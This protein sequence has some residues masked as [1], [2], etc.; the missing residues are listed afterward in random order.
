MRSPVSMPETLEGSSMSLATLW[1][2][3]YA[4]GLVRAD[5]VVGIE[6]HPTPALTG[7]PPHW[8]LTVVLP[9]VTGS[10]DLADGAPG[11]QIAPVHRTVIQTPDHP[12]DAPAA[13]ARLLAQL[14]PVNAAGVITA[15]VTPDHAGTGTGSPGSPDA[16]ADSGA[17]AP[18]P[19]QSGDTAAVVAAGSRIRF[20]FTP[21]PPA[22]ALS[23]ET[24]SHY[25]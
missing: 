2:Q 5:H 13:L 20:R 12:G 4:D 15:E 19:S 6:A 9:T 17:T 25:M 7:K 22:R 10:G 8:L 21:F 1:I 14:D 16:P 3:T 18:E 24:E 23:H 11:W